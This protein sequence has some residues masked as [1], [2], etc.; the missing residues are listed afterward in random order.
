MPRLNAIPPGC[1]FNPRC[2]RRFDRCLVERARVS[3]P[4]L[5]AACAACWLHGRCAY[6][7]ELAGGVSRDFDVSRPWLN[8]VLEREPRRCLRAVDEVSFDV[9]AR[10]DARA[11]R[12]IGL[13][14]VDR[15]APHRRPATPAGAPRARVER[16]R[17]PPRMQMIFQDPYASLNPRWRVRDIVAEPIRASHRATERAR[18]AS[19]WCRSVSRRD[20]GDKY[21]HEFSGG[22]RQRI[23]IA[24][25]LA[26]EPDFLVCDEPTS[27]LDVSVQAQI[28]NLMSDLQSRLGLTYLFISHNLAVVSPGRRPRRGHVPRPHRR[29]GAGAD[30]LLAPAP[31]LYAH[32]ARRRAGP[33]HERQAAHAGRAARCRTRSRR[34]PAARSIRAARTRTIDADA[35]CRRSSRASP[36]T[37]CRK[38]GFSG[39][40]PHQTAHGRRRQRRA[41]S[42][43][44]RAGR[45]S[46]SPARRPSGKRPCRGRR[47]T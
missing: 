11:G 19:C 46:R 34:P 40:L 16:P 44:G 29:A 2:P 28:L 23:S 5:A 24:R 4:A 1:A 20:D 31:S 10:R 7:L 6:A 17:R 32:A 3:L 8:R 13:R 45:R 27:A 43:H 47:G 21:P 42:R 35:R 39:C 41:P 37:P 9:D 14:Q 30:A 26:G 18:R 15:G 22:Q 25:A 33:R 36:A 38:A 12:R